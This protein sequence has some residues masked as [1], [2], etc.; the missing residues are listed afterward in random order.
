MALI[1]IRKALIFTQNN[2]LKIYLTTNDIKSSLNLFKLSVRLI[3][4]ARRLCD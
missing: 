4:F 2:I 1:L 3:E